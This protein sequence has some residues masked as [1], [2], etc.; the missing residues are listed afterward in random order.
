MPH[1]RKQERAMV[2]AEVR[3]DIAHVLTTINDSDKAGL[4]LFQERLASFFYEL[5][6]GNG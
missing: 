3:A 1:A 4:L 5:E 6:A 2:L